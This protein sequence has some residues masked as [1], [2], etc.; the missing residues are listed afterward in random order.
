MECSHQVKSSHGLNHLLTTMIH[1]GQQTKVIYPSKTSSNTFLFLKDLSN[2]NDRFASYGATA[3][4]A[5]SGYQGGD[6]FAGMAN[7]NYTN[8]PGRNVNP[9]SSIPLTIENPL[10]RNDR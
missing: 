3:T 2:E 7:G 4:D 1:H 9:S 8:I 10:Y 5:T 6:P